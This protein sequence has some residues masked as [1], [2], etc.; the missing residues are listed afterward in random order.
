MSCT[1]VSHR[2]PGLSALE[3]PVLRYGGLDSRAGAVGLL[4]Q[5][6][7]EGRRQ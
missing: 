2:E 5:A 4:K 1:N 3:S 6:S 7:A